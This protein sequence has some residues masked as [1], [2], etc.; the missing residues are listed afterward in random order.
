MKTKFLL[1]LF[2]LFIIP[3]KALAYLEDYSP[4]VNEKP[5]SP[6]MKKLVILE[7]DGYDVSMGIIRNGKKIP[8][9]KFLEAKGENDFFYSMSVFD[10]KGNLMKDSVKISDSSFIHEAYTSDLNLDGKRDFVIRIASGGTGLG[11]Y[12]NF[13]I[14]ALSSGNNYEV[15]SLRNWDSDTVNRDFI[16]VKKNGYIQFIHT[17]FKYVEDKKGNQHT[18]W[19]YNLLE[20]KGTKLILANQLYPSFPK[21]VWYTNKPNRK[22]SPFV[23]KTEMKNWAN[24]EYT[25]F[26][27]KD[28]QKE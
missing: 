10:D 7:E 14:F 21:W 28:K 5:K 2:F 23:G 4:F 12:Y 15:L 9:L 24:S 26:F 22:P 27:W 16:K 1:A 3:V 6:S 11:S 20:I 25:N 18:H 19:V 13:T 17:A 8:F